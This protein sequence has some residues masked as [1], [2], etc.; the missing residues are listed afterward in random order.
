MNNGGNVNRSLLSLPSQQGTQESVLFPPTG[1]CTSI[2]AGYAFNATS[3]DTL[4]PVVP[5][6]SAYRSRRIF[7][8]GL[9]GSSIK[10]TTF[11]STST[12][13]SIVE[14]NTGTMMDLGDAVVFESSPSAVHMFMRDLVA[15]HSD[16]SSF[17]IVVDN[18]KSG[19]T[20]RKWNAIRRSSLRRCS[21][22]TPTRW[23]SDSGLSLASS[24][25]D[26]RR[27]I[28]SM[29]PSC[30]LRPKNA[31][32]ERR[33]SFDPGMMMMNRARPI[34]KPQDHSIV[35][36]RQPQSTS[37]STSSGSPCGS[38]NSNVSISPQSPYSHDESSTTF[39]ARPNQRQQEQQRRRE[40]LESVSSLPEDTPPTSP[41]QGNSCISSG[42]E[43]D[44]SDYFTSDVEELEQKL[45][46]SSKP[47]PK[48]A[49]AE[50]ALSFALIS[51][52]ERLS[53]RAALAMCRPQTSSWVQVETMQ[54]IDEAMELLP[55]RGS[56]TDVSTSRRRR[57]IDYCSG[58]DTENEL[59]TTL[60]NHSMAMEHPELT[61]S[62]QHSDLNNAMLAAIDR[63]SVRAAL[64]LTN[65][66]SG[67]TS[68][69]TNDEKSEDEE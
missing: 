15:A 18:A 38:S 16:D 33:N 9:S 49:P 61:A 43:T 57:S 62:K 6:G 8:S 21:M 69:Y 22:P 5:M 1:T 3:T 39:S 12:T 24:P 40:F 45:K 28:H 48:A 25:D 10:S 56:V 65:T 34:L 13:T 23:S 26:T 67:Y 27:T 63:L 11:T 68:G 52:I 53:V 50:S 19:E 42:S 2:F 20:A 32:A 30:C 41:L 29:D 54:T 58:E 4:L 17:D 59:A 14:R 46:R 31:C 37:A 60:E 51:T 64:T 55:T 44:F 47:V 7:G 36:S 35:P 66:T